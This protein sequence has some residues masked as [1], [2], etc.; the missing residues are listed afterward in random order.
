MQTFDENLGFIPNRNP[1]EIMDSIYAEINMNEI[2]LDVI[3]FSSVDSS[4]FNLE[5]FHKLA[6][7]VQ[8]KINNDKYDGKIIIYK[9]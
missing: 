9:I 6:K 7:L 3:E 4:S 8:Q 5:T 2:Q 1:T